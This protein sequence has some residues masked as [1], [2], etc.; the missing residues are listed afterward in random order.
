LGRQLQRQ[1]IR[2]SRGFSLTELVVTIAIILILT[3]MAIPSLMRAYEAYRY[4]NA[5]SGVAGVLKLTRF[6]AI[7]RNQQV[8][9]QIQQSG[10]D[11]IIWA[12]TTPNGA[13][14][15]SEPQYL[16]TGSVSVLSGS[17]LPSSSAI[18]TSV[19]ALGLTALASGNIVIFDARGAVIL[20]GTQPPVY[21]VYIGNAARPDL[22][23]R[24]VVLLPSGV[25]HVWTAPST[26]PWQQV[27]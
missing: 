3:G 4:N 6:E 21:V 22:G 20:P 5:A 19:G 9:C 26:G 27:S 1:S 13:A 2:G 17:G 24:A 15:P 10:T 14:D 25:V 16:L 23:Y 12:D 11:W 7:R 18:A 8:K